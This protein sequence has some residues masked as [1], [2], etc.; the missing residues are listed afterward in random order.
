M[1]ENSFQYF[2]ENN[3][4]NEINDIKL[5]KSDDLKN[6]NIYR[7]TRVLNCNKIKQLGIF[8]PKEH[9][10]TLRKKSFPFI[11]K[12]DGTI[13]PFSGNENITNSVTSLFSK[14]KVQQ[15]CAIYGYI[16]V[17]HQNKEIMQYVLM[18]DNLY[19]NFS[20]KTTDIKQIFAIDDGSCSP[21]IEYRF[22][23]IGLSN[24][25]GVYPIK[26]NEDDFIEKYVENN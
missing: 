22:D 13:I 18:G 2:F 5:F 23:A 24:R 6:K 15:I 26:Y 10:S 9:V 3:N 17:L 25:G 21:Q 12:Y 1:G 16:F 8:I 20:Y 14:N 19:K 7:Q 4:M 11:L